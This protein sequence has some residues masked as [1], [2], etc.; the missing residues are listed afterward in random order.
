[1]TGTFYTFK[2]KEETYET[3]ATSFYKQNAPGASC[4]YYYGTAIKCLDGYGRYH[5][6]Q[7]CRFCGHFR[8][9]SC[10][11]HQCI[12]H[13]GLFCT[14]S[15]RYH[16]LYPVSWTEESRDGKQISQAGAFYY[17]SHFCFHRCA[18]TCFPCTAS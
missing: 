2:E 7:Q 1:M 5:D 12:D 17:N 3:T 4:S 14:G 15:R 11:F 9:F 16:Y 13:S 10:G 8:R 6:G 18:W